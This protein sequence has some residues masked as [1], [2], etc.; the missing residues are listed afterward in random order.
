MQVKFKTEAI[1]FLFGALVI[2]LNFGDDHTGPTIG[3]LDTIFGLRLWPLMDL[4]YP[5][6]SILLFLAYGEAKGGGT[7][8]FNR[9]TILPLAGYL[10]AL[11]LISVDDISTVLNLGLT[12]PET[13]WITAMWLYPILSFLTLFTYGQANEKTNK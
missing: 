2:M 1:V 4:I 13:Y 5:L 11:V 9:K 12:L 10:L 7:T 8:K 3:N 6:A